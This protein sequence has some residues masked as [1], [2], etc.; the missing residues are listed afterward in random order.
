MRK[1]DR[2]PFDWRSYRFCSRARLP[3]KLLKLAIIPY[4]LLHL[5]LCANPSFGFEYDDLEILKSDQEGIVFRYLVPD[6]S[7]SRIQLLGKSFDL[8]NI[9]KCGL[10]NI[11][12]KPQ[13]PV[14]RVIIAAPLDAE[15]SVETLDRE[16]ADLPG[17]NLAYGVIAEQD[18]DS[19]LGYNLIPSEAKERLDQHY[20][21]EIV[22]SA[23]PTFL[24]NQR[25]LELEIFPVQ[26][27]P[28]RKSVRYCSQI[29]VKVSFSGGQGEIF[30][31]ERDLFERIYRNVLV[32][33]EESKGWRKTAE[34]RTYSK[35]G[36]TDPFRY[37]DNWYKAIVRENGIY[38]IDRTML[39]QAGVPVS[40]MDP[41]ALRM[42][43]GGGKTLPIYGSDAFLEL[44]EVAIWVSGEQDGQFDSDDFILFFG[45]PTSDWEY[46]SAGRADGFYTNPYTNDNVFWLTY[47]PMP[48]LPDPK[49]M[50]T[51]DGSLVAQ[52]PLTPS[53]LRSSIHVE[54]DHIVFDNFYWY[55][56]NTPS[57]RLFVSLP[58]ALPQDT[59]FIKVKH[60]GSDPGLR[61]NGEPAEIVDWPS[62]G[63]VTVARSFNFHGGL[64]DTLDISFPSSALLDWYEIEYPRRFE[65]HD[66]QLFF[67]SPEYSG[68]VEYDISNLFSSA[69]VLFDVTDHFEIGRFEGI[70]TEGEFATFQDTV[71]AETKTRYLLADESR[72]KKPA[73]FFRDDVSHLKE[74][75]EQ[76][77]F[78]IITHA[79]FYQQALSLKDFRE[80]YNHMSVMVVGVQDVYD[81]FSGGLF[82]PVAIRDFLRYAYQHWAQPAPAFVLLVGDGNYDYRNN[83][84]TGA[85]NF[86]PPFAAD[87]SVSDDMYVLSG[88]TLNMVISRLPVSSEGGAGVVVSKIIDYE[89]EPEFGVWRNLIT[90]VADDEWGESGEI[91]GYWNRHTPDTETLAKS[92]VPPS[93]NISKIYLMEYPL[94][95]KREKPQAEEAV[96][97]A[98]NSGTLMV[99]FIGH[100]NPNVWAHERVLRRS[101]DIPR[102]ANKRKLPLVYS[103]SCS[104]GLFFSPMAE[105]MSEELL[106]AE[107]GGAIATISATGDVGASANAQLNFKVYDLLLNEDSPSIGE[108]FFIAKLTEP[109]S[110]NNDRKYVLFGDPVMKLGAP[111]LEVELT[112]VTPDTL[113][114]LSLISVRGE[115]RDTQGSRIT[116]FDGIAKITVFDSENT[117][118]HEIPTQSPST[119]SYDLPGLLM[120]KGDARVEGGEFQA[121]FV[122][123]KDISYGGSTGRISVYVQGQDQDGAGLRD[124]LVIGGSDTTVIDTVGPE[125]TLSFDDRPGFAPGETILPNSIL[126]I[127]IS[128]E[129]GVNITGEVGHG[130]TLVIDD[131]TQNQ[132][133][134]TG[135]FEYDLGD[136]RS[137]S[138]SHE[139]PFLAEGDRTLSIKAWDNANNS[140]L[141][142]ARVKVRAERELELT[143][144]MNYPNPF[145]DATGFYYHLSQDADRVEIKIFTLA[146]KMIRHIP[147]AS[148][149]AG[150]DYS[151][152]PTW[153]GKD[154]EGDQVANGVY[155]YKIMAEGTVNGERKTKEA[156]GKAVVVR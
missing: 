100:G 154:Q 96:V 120:F 116:T 11:P 32:N 38:R 140:S 62:F 13:L 93:F 59:C 35:P 138:V 87:P 43:S 7:Q 104:V 46:D 134:L 79:D 101:Q 90:L 92:Y 67:E 133:D 103:S 47:D 148:S 128:D 106:R 146:G 39:V 24:R 28:V 30:K 34:T 156:Y 4:A 16:Q 78:L 151:N 145:S 147:F 107:N 40:S 125:I 135:G 127:S 36:M 52:D 70:V 37:S 97:D 121:H 61:V 8:I 110:E 54:Q 153:D 137:G 69:A 115:V 53:K 57:A 144:V 44:K 95:Y 149:R 99:N 68:V 143:E 15:I 14:R 10:S 33:Y 88:D 109:R 84:G 142:L 58:G 111:R 113:S 45:W 83:L 17:I 105:G 42:F 75:S 29:V 66:R 56:M 139:L 64:V 5:G 132:I 48:S 108:A 112:Q 152:P 72:V 12:G 3:F 80:G 126:R 85:R 49:R 86:I 122:V 2:E 19:R 31:S 155:I 6:F 130:I 27:N 76:V 26:Y 25:I 1:L 41:R 141:V 136:Y 119:V 60:T 71:S 82:D 74:A 73:L 81:Q 23:P 20:P 131:D 63:S 77:D 18:E 117:R 50:Q 9:P 98:F 123:P 150:T 22:S 118:T 124:S 51:K 94:D 129:H 55:W 102:L 114:A 89:R 65:C 21:P 91:D